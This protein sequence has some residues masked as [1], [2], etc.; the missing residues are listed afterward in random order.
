[1]AVNDLAEKYC[2]GF[3]SLSGRY[4]IYNI[5]QNPGRAR[6]RCASATLQ[7]II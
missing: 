1:M 3:A 5:M 2:G 4:S 6:L 7:R